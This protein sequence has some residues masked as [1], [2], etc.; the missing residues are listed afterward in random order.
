MEIV[1]VL[2]GIVLGHAKC[3]AQ[4]CEAAAQ[5]HVDPYVLEMDDVEVWIDSC[6]A[7]LQ[8]RADDI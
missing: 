3:W 4:D 7:H 2:E 6:E 1:H 8:Q 5:A